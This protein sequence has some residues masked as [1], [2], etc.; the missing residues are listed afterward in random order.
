MARFHRDV[1]EKLSFPTYYGRNLDAFNDCLSDL[2]MD[3]VRGTLLVFHRFD[4]FV[5]RERS[6]AESILDILASQSRYHSLL[7]QRLIVLVQSNDP[8]IRFARIGCCSVE[9]NPAEWRDSSRGL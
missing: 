7:G 4:C 6:T 9:W 1:A 8:T 3:D 2:E 5:E